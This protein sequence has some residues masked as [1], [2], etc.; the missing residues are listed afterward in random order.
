LA[1]G[2]VSS[3]IQQAAGRTEQVAHGLRLVSDGL[4]ENGAAAA[5]V[6]SAADLLGRQAG[7]LRREVDSFLSTIRAA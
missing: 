2:E 1:I 7:V 6:Q 5:A 4:G 3:N